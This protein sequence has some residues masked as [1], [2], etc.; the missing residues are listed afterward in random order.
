MDELLQ[1]VEFALHKVGLGDS[2]SI[3]GEHD[4]VGTEHYVVD[5]GTDDVHTASH[6]HSEFQSVG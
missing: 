1:V 3:R 6:L 5:S 4:I 2:S